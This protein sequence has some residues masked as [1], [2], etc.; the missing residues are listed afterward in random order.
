MRPAARLR[1]AGTT[2]EALGGDSRGGAR[3]K[4]FG[5]FEPQNGGGEAYA[6]G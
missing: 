4:S 5:G 1:A 2:G 3:N 6:N